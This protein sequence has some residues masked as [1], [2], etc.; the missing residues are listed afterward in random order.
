MRTDFW[1]L[2]PLPAFWTILL[3]NIFLYNID[4]GK[5]PPPAMYTGFMNESQDTFPLK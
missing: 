5:P 4:I 2:V 1:T 3:D